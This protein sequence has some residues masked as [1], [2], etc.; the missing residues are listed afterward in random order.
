VLCCKHTTHTHI[1]IYIY[2]FLTQVGGCCGTNPA[3]IERLSKAVKG[4]KPRVVSDDANKSYL[5]LSGLEPMILKPEIRFVN[6]GERCNVAG[7]KKFK[8]LILAGKF[9]EALAIA[10]EQ[11]ENGAQVL[12]VNMDEGLL[13]GKAAMSKFLRL[14]V[15]EPEISR[16]PFCVDSSKFEVIIEGLK[17]VQGK[18]IV[19]SIS[20]KV[21]E[22]EFR[23]QAK[24]VKQL[25]AA[26]VVMAFDEQGQAADEQ[27][28]VEICS[29]AFRILTKELGF[30]PTDV[31]FDPN[32]LTIAT[33]IEE[34]NNYGV[35][36]I[37]ATR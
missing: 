8:N 11:V 28:K 30:D 2:I 29:R 9:P 17:Q 26:V 24:L 36:F 32:I 34:H 6:I 31:I 22:E 3:Y 14:C 4:L 20:L 18:C 21:G 19:N 37:N 5:R 15:T 1:Y 13:D 23:R 33:G 27:R 25:G 16:V 10:R 7:S 12:D 35:D